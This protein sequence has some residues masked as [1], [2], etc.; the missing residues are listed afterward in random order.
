V[1][2][3]SLWRGLVHDLSKFLPSEWTPY[4]HAFYAPDG[5]SRYME[6]PEFNRAWLLHQHRNPHH[7][8]HWC[9]RMDCGYVAVLEMPREFAREMVADWIGAGMA[10]GK[11]DTLAWYEQNADKMLLHP[12][13]REMAEGLLKREARP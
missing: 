5:S 9:L 2:G 11:P 4:V 3:C 12:N 10:Q 8:Q 7:W 6:T 13:T 1:T